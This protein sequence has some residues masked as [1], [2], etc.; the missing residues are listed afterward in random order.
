M[1]QLIH[2][3]E[4]GRKALKDEIARRIPGTLRLGLLVFGTDTQIWERSE[5]Q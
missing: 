2:D 1:S 3:K 4:K 5:K